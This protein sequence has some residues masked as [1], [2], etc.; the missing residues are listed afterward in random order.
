M[1]MRTRIYI[2]TIINISKLCCSFAAVCVITNNSHYTA[3]G[4]AGSPA[5]T[6]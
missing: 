4:E 5:Q 1:Y 3:R 6:H 2:V